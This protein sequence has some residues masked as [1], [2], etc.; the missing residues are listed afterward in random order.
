MKESAEKL[1]YTHVDRIITPRMLWENWLL[2]EETIITG[3]GDGTANAYIKPMKI[4]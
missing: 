2:G 1:R 3:N 4:N